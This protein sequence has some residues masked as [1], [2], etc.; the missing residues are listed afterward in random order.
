MEKLT[1]LNSEN[2]KYKVEH[3]EKGVSGIEG[4][5][6]CNIIEI[7]EKIYD[8][9]CKKLGERKNVEIRLPE[10]I[11]V[12]SKKD[13]Q[14]VRAEAVYSDGTVASKKIIWDFDRIDFSQKGKQKIYGEIYCSHF[15]FPIASDRADPD[16]FK[17]K[18]KYYF[19]ATW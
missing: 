3:L 13:L 18:G 1:F 9:L 10:N 2:S 4:A 5:L 11:K 16:V 12:T 14:M 15:A 8:Y 6:P 17:W 7:P 19:I